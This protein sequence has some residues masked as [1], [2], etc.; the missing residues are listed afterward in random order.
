[1]DHERWMDVEG[2]YNVRDLGGY[3]TS[4]GRMTRW[5]VYLRA[6][7]MNAI[8]EVGQASLLR[9][10]LKRIIDLRQ[11]S[12]RAARGSDCNASSL[13]KAT[14]IQYAATSLRWPPE[15]LISAPQP[16]IVCTDLL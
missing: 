5:G 7:N 9:Y 1:M 13:C 11:S 16:W 6:D 2:A 15:G 14:Y 3:Q 4:D 12:A 8:S 10:G